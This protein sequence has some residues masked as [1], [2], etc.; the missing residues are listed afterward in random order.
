MA[1]RGAGSYKKG[2]DFERK[3]AKL[4]SEKFGVQ[5]KRTGAQESS[6][7]H[8]GDV[9]AHRG[10]KTIL[11]DFFWECKARESW[12]LIDWLQKAQDDSGFRPAVVIATRNYEAE[13]AF[14]KLEDFIRL[15]IEL[16]GYRNEKPSGNNPRRN[17]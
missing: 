2:A 5:V 4:F 10:E 15:L 17:G 1:S 11:N 14:L 9:N 7:V 16:D 13:Y 6:K 12:S 8:G 3:I